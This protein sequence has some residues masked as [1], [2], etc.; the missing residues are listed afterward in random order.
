[1]TRRLLTVLATL[2][3]AA[4]APLAAQ[5]PAALFASSDA[6]HLT[7]TAPLQTLI[8][9]RASE[10][11]IAGTLTDPSGNQLPITLALRG[12]T[13]RTSEIC[14]FPPLRVEFTAPP[15]PT[16]IFAG[17]RKLKL[18]THCRSSASFQQNVLLEYAA[19]GMYNQLTPRSFRARLASIDYRDS[20]GRP[21]VSRAG[22]F[23]E[24]LKDVAR[25]NGTHEAHAP[26][27]IPSN[28]LSPADAGRYALFQYMLSNY[29]WSMRAG[30]AGADCCHN[31]ELIGNTAP[32]AAIPVPYDFDYSGLVGAPY[33]VPPE[34]LSISNV[35][36]RLY[37]GYC[38]HNA[39]ALAAARQMRAA[40]PQILAVL[41][42]T[43][44][45]EPR[46]LRTASAYLER[47]F[48]DI[49]TDAELGAKVLNR[50]VG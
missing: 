22:F 15:P 42:Q 6:I 4:P 27:R 16:S 9:N 35:K 45:L 40:R 8:R 21:I 19:Y 7:V 44:G 50:C 37:R 33:A 2:L 12:I 47:F 24:P 32:G 5:K 48:V 13:R 43:P 23:L 14:E 26:N 20:N 30:P 36:Q 28:F 46:T 10:A 18:V 17:Q 31:A 34:G 29:D 39:E 25:R 11:A 38:A 1:M 49:A 3:L 41:S